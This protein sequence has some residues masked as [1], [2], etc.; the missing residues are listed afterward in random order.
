MKTARWIWCAQNGIHD[1]NQTVLFKKEFEL[2]KAG[3]ASL[4]ITA[5]SWYRV[6]INGKWVHDGPGRAYPNHFQ[7]DTYEVGDLLK[8][9]K[10]KIKV[11]ARYFGI[12]T[13]HQLPL[14]AGLLAQ[15]NTT[16]G[17]IDSDSSWQ[18]SPSHAWQQWTPKISIQMEPVEEYDARL[19]K[20]VDWQPAVE[21]KRSGKVSS[22]NV[23]LLTKKPRRFTKLHSATIV[24]RTNRQVTVPVT[25]IAQPGVIEANG[26][27]TR[28]VVLVS[29]FSVRKKQQFNFGLEDKKEDFTNPG[30]KE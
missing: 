27:T 15:L 9:G 10:N 7:Y 1:Y 17:T 29:T 25:Q 11:I 14:Q 24:K 23:G 13:F 8:K 18:A 26:N 22:R 3:D 21:M 19:E 4:C 20:I 2:K 28:P 30:T 6:S 12:G 16:E 5:D